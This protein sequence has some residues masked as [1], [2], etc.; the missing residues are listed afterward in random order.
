MWAWADDAIPI[1]A[2]RGIEN[3]RA[4]GVERD[5]GMLVEPVMT[6]GRAEGWKLWRSQGGC[7][8]PIASE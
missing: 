2:K 1:E 7:S 5:L 3:V 4:F 8:T 6:G